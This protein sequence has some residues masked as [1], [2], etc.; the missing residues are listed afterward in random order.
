MHICRDVI[1]YTR[2]HNETKKQ[3]KLQR[4]IKWKSRWLV[5]VPLWYL[6]FCIHCPYWLVAFPF[7]AY[8]G[9]PF[10]HPLAADVLVGFD[11]RGRL[12]K[13]LQVAPT[14]LLTRKARGS[15]LRL[16]QVPSLEALVDG[17]WRSTVT[18]VFPVTQRR[19]YQ[20]QPFVSRLRRT[21]AV[22]D[23]AFTAAVL[24]LHYWTRFFPPAK[25]KSE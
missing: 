5:L 12:Y 16:Y 21:A 9:L 20:S 13:A 2:K 24:A 8:N 18:E 14:V 4:V 23:R 11:T 6:F 22:T 3:L 7:L 10:G 25:I 19:T 17:H 1:G 15:T